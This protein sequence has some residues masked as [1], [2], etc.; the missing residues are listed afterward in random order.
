MNRSMQDPVVMTGHSPVRKRLQEH[1]WRTM[2]RARFRRA[3]V[4]AFTA[5]ALC[6]AVLMGVM[7]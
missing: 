4:L 3:V 5:G 1:Y 6:G 7:G 2:A